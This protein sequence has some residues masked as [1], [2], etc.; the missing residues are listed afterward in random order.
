MRHQITTRRVVCIFLILVLWVT[1]CKAQPSISNPVP[2]PDEWPNREWQTSTPEAQG[3]DSN[4]LAQ[5][6]EEPFM[7]ALQGW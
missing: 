2:E 3:M 7:L 4:L 5:M 1:G 6:L